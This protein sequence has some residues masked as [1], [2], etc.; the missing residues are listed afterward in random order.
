MNKKAVSP[1]IATVLLIVVV[2]G[3]GA[4][5]T[6]IARTYISDSKEQTVKTS[7]KIKCSTSPDIDFTVLGDEPQ[8]CKNSTHIQFMI[9]DK[10]GEILDF[11]LKVFSATDL[12]TNDSLMPSGPSMK[13]GD[14]R[15]FTVPYSGIPESDITEIQVIP[16]LKD[17]MG[18]WAYCSSVAL[19]ANILPTC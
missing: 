1:L 17:Q 5:I 7:G 6:S 16:K 8:Y 19:K 3:V 12:F 11:Q 13:Q 9:D 14:T 10:A 2:V 4:I 15:L 18:R